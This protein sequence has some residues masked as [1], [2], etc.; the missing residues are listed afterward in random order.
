MAAR[1]DRVL[2]AVTGEMLEGVGEER[3]VD[4]RE[5]VFPH[6]V[7]ER[8]QPCPLSAYEDDCRQAHP[9]GRPMPS[10][11]KP[12]ARSAA[13]SSKLRPSTMSRFRIRAPASAQSRS[14]SSGHSVT[15]TAA[16]AP[17][18]ASSADS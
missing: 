17:S 13:G 1:D 6:A 2:D 18:R 14:R 9:I 11:A 4:E 16:L 7:G 8:A 10:Y 15:T 5:H 12:S 3:F